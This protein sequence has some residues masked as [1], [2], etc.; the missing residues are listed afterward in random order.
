MIVAVETI[1]EEK[2]KVSA[3]LPNNSA[4]ASILLTWISAN[5]SNSD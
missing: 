1:S 5:S 3:T 2:Q 4:G